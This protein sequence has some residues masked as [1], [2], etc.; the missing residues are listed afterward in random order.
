MFINCYIIMVVI[1]C[2]LMFI[3]WSTRGM[4]NVLMKFV[5]GWITLAGLI[6]LLGR[7]GIINQLN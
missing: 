2:S 3:I 4:S 1:T 5:L 7:F 6:I